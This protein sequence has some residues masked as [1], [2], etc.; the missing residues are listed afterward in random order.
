MNDPGGAN[1][2]VQ[3]PCPSSGSCWRGAGARVC[4]AAGGDSQV[5]ADGGNLLCYRGPRTQWYCC[6]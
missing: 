1:P 4:G 3:Q 5:V 2:E 6:H